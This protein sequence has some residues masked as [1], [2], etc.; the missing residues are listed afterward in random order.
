MT[1]VTW[2][3]VMVAA[4]ERGFSRL[5]PF[6]AVTLAR[7]LC[8]ALAQTPAGG[9][10]DLDAVTLDFDGQV[11]AEQQG[12]QA[13]VEVARVLERLLPSAKDDELERIISSA[14]DADATLVELERRL[15]HWLVKQLQVH[16]SRDLPGEFLCWLFPERAPR[17]VSPEVAT[18]FETERAVAVLEP[19]ARRAVPPSLRSTRPGLVWGAAAGVVGLGLLIAGVVLDPPAPEAP[20]VPMPVS[21]APV[22][23]PAPPK[24]EPPPVEP[25]EQRAPIE[26]RLPRRSSTV[27]A[28]VTL[29][30]DVHGIDLTNAGLRLDAPSPRWALKTEPSSRAE[31]APPYAALYVAALD[32]AGRVKRLAVV[33]P[34]QWTTLDTPSARLFAVQPDQRPSEGS[35]GLAIAKVS[36]EGPDVRTAKHRPDVLTDSMAQ[37]EGRRFV[38]DGLNPTKDYVV[39]LRK[40]AMP[41]DVVASA[42]IPFAGARFMRGFGFQ[43]LGAPLDQVLLLP[44]VPVEFSGVSRLSLVVLTTPNAPV[45]EATVDVTETTSAKKARGTVNMLSPAAALREQGQYLLDHGDPNAAVPFFTRCLQLEPENV[46]CEY[47]RER[48]EALTK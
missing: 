5:P 9:A 8:V 37:Q 10:L 20:P 31:P 38:L 47:G 48:A 27:P 23:K 28:Q 33:G 7:R 14:T 16:P 39:T 26:P 35:F 25:L 29:A 34:K 40:Q 18:W 32:E 6:L 11:R 12:P 43:V 44:G 36:A 22:A 2:R 46:P 24:V 21:R 17:A 15:G 4:S 13:T 41:L 19:V 1:P 42:T 45:R 30:T 3:E